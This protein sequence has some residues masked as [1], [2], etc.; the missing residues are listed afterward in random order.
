MQFF[1]KETAVIFLAT[2]AA[3]VVGTVIVVPQIIKHT[4]KA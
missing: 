4:K 2:L 3:F 1:N